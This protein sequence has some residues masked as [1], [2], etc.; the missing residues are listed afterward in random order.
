MA[1][2]QHWFT[3]SHKYILFMAAVASL[4]AGLVVLQH[5]CMNHKSGDFV[6]S[7]CLTDSHM[8]TV[9]AAILTVVGLILTSA[10]MNA[11]ESYRTAKLASGI[12]EGV[13]IAM[14]S[15]SVKYRLHALFTPWA[16][17]VLLIILCSNA[18][19]SI[20]TLANLG[21]KTAGVY[22][23]NNST[24][25]VFDAYSHYNASVTQTDFAFLN[26][27]I[28]VLTKM[29]DY[30]TSAT[31]TVVEHGMGVA[32][33]VVR[34]GYLGVVN[35]EQSDVTNALRRLE[36]VATITSTCKSALLSGPLSEVVPANT[37]AVNVTF[38]LP[39]DNFAE[40]S[41]YDVLYE[42]TSDNTL[43]FQ[44][45]ISSAV[46][47][48]GDCTSLGPNTSVMGATTTCT[49]T[50][51]VQDQIIIYT[52][53]ADSV[54]PV[55]VVSNATTVSVSDL[56]NLIVSYADSIEAASQGLGDSVSYS[57]GVLDEYNFFPSGSFN[58]SQSNVLHTKLCAAT[59]IALNL[60]W[61]NYGTNST[62]SSSGLN[63]LV[64]NAYITYNAPVPLYN[65]VQLTYIST[66]NVAAIAG[67]ITGCACLVSLVGIVFAVASRINVKPVTDSALL[68]NA[69]PALLARKQALLSELSND[70]Q[71][72]LDLEFRPE[73]IL[74]CR[75]LSVKYPDPADP[76]TV[77]TFSRVNISYSK[78]GAV[79][80]QSI[81]YY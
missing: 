72:Q 16:P 41:I 62:T 70:P 10:V 28:G 25:I 76:T 12:N 1:R 27:A 54:T 63:G 11:V 73:S 15:Q 20:Q 38:V 64:G 71:G 33:S 19:N 36:T 30:R 18:P 61:E 29:R 75:E 78:A 56:A 74:Y 3:V 31:S 79:P 39:D 77:N 6:N 66:A 42:V 32:T 65:V 57:E 55:G 48:L 4:C 14:A 51:I 50:L 22:V 49:S 43:L 53:G 69:D 7:Y 40:A 80:H 17:A 34:D 2:K 68:Y 37:A 60:L 52:V 13:Y 45:T 5:F 81:R 8:R 26:T 24:A 47:H 67:V 21:I 44:S 35:I 23:R 59:S 9:L 46:C 58:L